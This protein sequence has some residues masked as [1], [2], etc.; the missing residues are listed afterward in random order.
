MPVLFSLLAEVQTDRAEVAA[1]DDL[2]KPQ[3]G[4]GVQVT[5]HRLESETDETGLMLQ[6]LHHASDVLSFETAVAENEFQNA[7]FCLLE[8]GHDALQHRIGLCACLGHL[9]AQH[10]RLGHG[11]LGQQEDFFVFEGVEG[12]LERGKSGAHGLGPPV[13]NRQS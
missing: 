2:P 1:L 11:W 6:G 9:Q 12:V 10:P 5:P 13:H 8:F 3:D 4:V 7:H